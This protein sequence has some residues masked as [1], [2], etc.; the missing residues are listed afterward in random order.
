MI[1]V[2]NDAWSWN[3]ATAIKI[4]DTNDFGHV[5]FESTEGTIW[6]VAPE[7]LQC[8]QIAGDKNEYEKLVK[9]PSFQKDWEMASIVTAAREL[10]GPIA[11]NEKYCLKLPLVF[12]GL[13]DPA[14]F[15]KIAL[16]KLLTLTGALG[17]EI[18]DLPDGE[19]ISFDL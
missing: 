12:G 1:E 14:N 8:N 13:Y 10:V 17:F 19:T 2:I 7:T 4:L 3:G 9:D 6:R 5:L 15:D 11:G 18:K 16:E